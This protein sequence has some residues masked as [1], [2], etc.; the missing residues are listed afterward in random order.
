M[1]PASWIFAKHFQITPE[2]ST[3]L[4]GNRI[5]F[6][7]QAFHQ[8]PVNYYA[9][10]PGVNQPQPPPAQQQQ[11]QQLQQ[12]HQFGGFGDPSQMMANPAMGMAMQFMP[13]LVNQGREVLDRQVN[14]YVAASRLKYYFSVDTPYVVRKL[15]RILFPFT[16]KA[17]CSQASYQDPRSGT[18]KQP[19]ALPV[20][21]AV[22]VILKHYSFMVIDWRWWLSG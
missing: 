1:S 5:S 17:S 4:N 16:H 8:G 6:A 10:P 13:G 11:Q 14:K 9:A 22:C 2:N 3:D 12:Q 7:D 20:V 18:W 15:V 21:C 19:S